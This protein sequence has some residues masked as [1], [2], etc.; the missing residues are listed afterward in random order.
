MVT[1]NCKAINVK[2]SHYDMDI[3][4]G[5]GEGYLIAVGQTSSKTKTGWGLAFNYQHSGMFITGNS[6]G[7][8]ACWDLN[9]VDN[10]QCMS[11]MGKFKN[12]KH[13]C[14]ANMYM[15][16]SKICGRVFEDGPPFITRQCAEEYHWFEEFEKYGAWNSNGIQSGNHDSA[17]IF[18]M[19]LDWCHWIGVMILHRYLCQV[20][21][22]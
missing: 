4:V 13:S 9:M 17:Q 3:T 12:K 14:D 18:V 15:K 5:T 21:I 7:S 20:V 2:P 22:M 6:D 19:S 16:D 11:K 10:A 8:I 1:N